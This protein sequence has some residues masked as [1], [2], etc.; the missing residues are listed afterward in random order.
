MNLRAGQAH[1]VRHREPSAAGA[2]YDEGRGRGGG[3]GGGGG[4]GERRRTL[5]RHDEHAGK[6][7][8]YCRRREAE[9]ETLN[10]RDQESEQ[11]G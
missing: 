5:Y 9:A 2:E 11:S 6:S 3:G 1:T 4:S 10:G 8:S 7:A